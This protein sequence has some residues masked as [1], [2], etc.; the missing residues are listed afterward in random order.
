MQALALLTVANPVSPIS[1][2][3]VPLIRAEE[4][5]DRCFYIALG[6]RFGSLW[7]DGKVCI[8]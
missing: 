7:G 5:S 1:V 6:V 8:W 4:S 3:S 2:V